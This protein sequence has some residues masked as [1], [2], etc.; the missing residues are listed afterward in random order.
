MNSMSENAMG[1]QRSGGMC[2]E[3]IELQDILQDIYMTC[4]TCRSSLEKRRR[5]QAAITSFSL[6]M[7]ALPFCR[8]F[9][10][11]RCT[12]ELRDLSRKFK[13]S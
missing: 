13:I 8:C 12:G 4:L 2:L 3:M 11:S 5:E 9:G 6:V 1:H 10:G 7:P